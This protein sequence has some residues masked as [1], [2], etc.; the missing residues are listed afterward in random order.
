MKKILVTGSL[1][2]IGSALTKYLTDKGFFVVGLDTG[3]FRDSVLYPPADTGTI[4]KDV[5]DIK[6]DDLSGFD[7]VV[8]LAGI[9]NDPLHKIDAARIYD[10]TRDYTLNIANI[11]K[12]KGIKFIFSS[13]CSVYGVN[14]GLADENTPVNPQTPYSLNKVQIEEGLRK[15]SDNNFSPIALRFATVFGPSPRLRFDVMVNMFAGMAVTGGAIVLN[16]D[17]SSWRPNV[18]VSDVCEAISRSIDLKHKGSGLLV[19]NV[20]D[21]A[22]NL[23]VIEIAKIVANTLPGCE[24]KFLTKDP[25]LDSEG[26]IKD[27]K[28][29]GGVDVR[30][31]KVSFKKIRETIPGFKCERTLQ[32]GAKELVR[33]FKDLSLIYDIFK[34]RDFY[35]LQK[36][37]YLFNNGFLSKDLYWLKE[38]PNLSFNSFK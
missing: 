33:L 28:V 23:Q 18:H 32:D 20:G 15:I 7:A 24:V 2:Y 27:R 38:R 34:K 1:G 3:F 36:L 5:R 31:Y 26:L 29:E 12:N 10:P 22:N 19:L 21:E 30:T 8:H 11:C 25:D 4:L 17:G 9:S 6:E 14:E 37:E 13:S 16:S 35:R